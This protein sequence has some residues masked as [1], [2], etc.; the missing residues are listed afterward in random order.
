MLRAVLFAL[1]LGI[2][3]AMHI[4]EG[5]YCMMLVSWGAILLCILTPL[6]LGL[7]IYRGDLVRALSAACGLSE[8]DAASTPRFMEVVAGLR[9]LCLTL[10]GLAYLVGLIGTVGTLDSPSEL[11]AWIALALLA[12]VYTVVLAEICLVPLMDRM[13]RR[14]LLGSSELSGTAAG[15]SKRAFLTDLA[16]LAVMTCSILGVAAVVG[17]QAGNFLQPAALGII[18]AFAPLNAAFH[19]VAGHHRAFTAGH[20]PA[21]CTAGERAQH[22]LVLRSA[23]DII[24]ALGTL[25]VIIGLIHVLGALDDPNKIGQGLA[26]CL[27]A[28][29]YAVVAAELFVAPRIRRLV[30]A[31]SP[32]EAELRAVVEAAGSNRAPLRGSL[33][34]IGGGLLLFVLCL[35]AVSGQ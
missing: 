18:L 34:A 22:Q 20:S 3:V 16:V 24:Y 12:V 32:E 14:S 17:D 35:H 28:P 33:V 25:G 4:F 2:V 26:I 5:G 15:A 30:A 23:R 27:V 9:M 7:V 31:G 29:L 8:L 6:L 1:G 11:G 21:E 13:A 19:G 10:G